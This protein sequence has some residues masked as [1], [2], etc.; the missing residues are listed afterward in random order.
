MAKWVFNRQTDCLAIHHF[1][2][3]VLSHSLYTNTQ[4]SRWL[5]RISQQLPNVWPG[6][7]TCQQN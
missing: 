3:Q 6:A 4:M 7:L 5:V 2:G 1:T